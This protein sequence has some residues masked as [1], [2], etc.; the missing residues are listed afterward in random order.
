MIKD[1]HNHKN[2]VLLVFFQTKSDA[3]H[4][5]WFNSISSEIF[6]LIDVRTIKSPHLQL[7]FLANPEITTKNMQILNKNMSELR[8]HC[9]NRVIAWLVGYPN[10]MILVNNPH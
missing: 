7:Y 8:Y 1:Y 9:Q 5:L 6:T 3:L 10:R 2:V 4:K